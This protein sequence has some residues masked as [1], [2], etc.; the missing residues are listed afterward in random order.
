[1]A[2]Q[3]EKDALFEGALADLRTRRVASQARLANE[4][5]GVMFDELVA[6]VRSP[7]AETGNPYGLVT[8]PELMELIDNGSLPPQPPAPVATHPNGKAPSKNGRGR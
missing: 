7:A 8:S 2:I 4:M 5:G 3:A 1:M 6:A